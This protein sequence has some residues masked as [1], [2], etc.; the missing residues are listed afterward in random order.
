[1]GFNWA[2]KGLLFFTANTCCTELLLVVMKCRRGLL[3]WYR[4]VCNNM[5]CCVLSCYLTCH[6]FNIGTLVD[7]WNIVIY[8]IL[9]RSLL[10]FRDGNSVSKKSTVCKVIRNGQN[11]GYW[12][13]VNEFWIRNLLSAWNKNFPDGHHKMYSGSCIKG[14]CYNLFR[15]PQFQCNTVHNTDCSTVFL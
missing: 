13:N 12:N 9:L 14:H 10:T 5:H 11:V 7:V 8:I 6:L 4:T 1:M 3:V 15:I 2:F